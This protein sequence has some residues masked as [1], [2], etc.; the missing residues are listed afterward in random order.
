[1]VQKAVLVLDYTPDHELAESVAQHVAVEYA[2]ETEDIIVWMLSYDV[3]SWISVG[4]ADQLAAHK[5]DAGPNACY[6][7]VIL[8]NDEE[9]DEILNEE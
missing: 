2:D 6:M 5:R 1:M 7:T 3:P 9:A 4:L 8:C